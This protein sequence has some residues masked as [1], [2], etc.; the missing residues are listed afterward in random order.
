MKVATVVGTRPQ[1]VKAAA[2][3]PEIRKCAKEIFIHTGQHYDVEMSKV[4]FDALHMPD[5]DYNLGIGSASHGRQ[6]G[7]MLAAVEDVLL[8]EKPDFVLVHGDTNSTLA[9]ALAAAKLHIPIGH[10]EA[11]L[12]SGNRS[13]PE[14]VNRIL[15]DHLSTLLFAPTRN[16]VENLKR[17]GIVDGVHL[18]GDV[19]YDLAMRSSSVASTKEVL[20]KMH[21][22][23]NSYVLATIHRPVNTDDERNLRNIMDAL[24]ECGKQVVLPVHPRTAKMIRQFRISFPRSPGKM[25]RTK[26]LDYLVFL[27]LLMGAEKVVT[28][29]GGV[30]KEAYFFGKP[31]IT[32]RDETEWRETVDA[33]WNILVGARKS[34][35]VEAIKTFEPKGRP[36]AS[37]GDGH[38]AERIAELVS[39]FPAHG[40]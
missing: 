4:F 38:A 2:L 18:V 6:T 21:L 32:L 36:K 11:G 15:V 33:G 13:M 26:P 19:M 31:C 7:L 5:P 23:H 22:K 1:F 39:G 14:E 10:V 8:K 40:S 12:R 17:E 24:K 3:S 30:Q 34:K 29:S 16:S 20:G 27:G 28:D 9:G 25:I 37:F 35:I